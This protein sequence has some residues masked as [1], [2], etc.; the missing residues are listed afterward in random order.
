MSVTFRSFQST[1]FCCFPAP[2]CP[3]DP[4]RVRALAEVFKRRGWAST[5]FDV[6]EIPGPA[7]RGYFEL[8]DA[9]Q[10]DELEAAV[11]ARLA[12]VAFRLIPGE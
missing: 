11:E 2:R 5:V 1:P 8:R 4:Q 6:A 3:A 12:S 10:V 7:W 9:S